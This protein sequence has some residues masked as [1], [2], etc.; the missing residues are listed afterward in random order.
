MTVH[1][2]RKELKRRLA[3]TEPIDVEDVRCVNGHS[4]RELMQQKSRELLAEIY[5]RA[6]HPDRLLRHMFD[7]YEHL[8]MDWVCSE[9]L[10]W[11]GSL[12]DRQATH[13]RVALG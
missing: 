3:A 4:R 11:E 10:E 1:D 6:K 13:I 8:A 12:A 9:T 5:A 2:M 7:V